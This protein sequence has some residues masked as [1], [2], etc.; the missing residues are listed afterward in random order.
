MF[1]FIGSLESYLLD[2]L[3]K[4]LESETL[5]P[6]NTRLKPSFPSFARS[7][8]FLF[9][10]THLHA[11]STVDISKK[12]TLISILE[13]SEIYLDDKNLSKNEL[14]RGNYLQTYTKSIVNIA[15]SKRTVWIRFKLKNSSSKLIEKALILNSPSLEFISLY[16]EE[17][18]KP[19]LS[20]I[21][22]TKKKHSTIYYS[23]MISIPANSVK[24]YYLKVASSHKSFFFKLT[25]QNYEDFMRDDAFNQAPRL[26]MLGLLLGLMIYAFLLAFYSRDKS[27]FYYASYLFFT[28]WH[29][30]TFL[31]LTQI[32]FPH[33]FVL[34]DMK[35]IIIKLGLALFFAV[36][37]AIS[38][39]KIDKKSWLFKI[40]ILFIL[41]SI[42]IVFIIKT[43]SIVLLIGVAFV[44]FNFIASVLRYLSGYKQ[45]RLFIFGFGVVA[46]A[47][48][49]VVLD[50][51]GLSSVLNHFPNILMWA[52]TIEVLAL[53]LAFADRY[54][55]LEE[56][57][58]ID[59]KNREQIIKNK[60]IQ[61]TAQLNEALKLKSLLL[62]E[63]HHR[64][65]NNLQIIISMIRLQNDKIEDI[66]IKDKFTSLE[67]R[68][69]AIAKTYNML[70]VDENLEN[71]DM[72][73]YIESLLLDIESSMFKLSSNITLETDINASLPLG[74][75]VYIGIIINELVTNSYKYAFENNYGSIFI[76]LNRVQNKYQLTISDTGKGFSYDKNHPSLGLK[77]IHALII[78]Q[79]KGTIIMETKKSS[80]YIIGFE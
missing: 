45:A 29:Q 50:S 37:F 41:L 22:H 67:N 7:L 80:K 47:Y 64:V 69:N 77:L 24:E 48:I 63:V 12:N 71:I 2:F 40:Y 21:S 79:L 76:S 59:D 46:T 43:L 18:I 52:V 19:H 14:L 15:Q 39:L 65:K 11:L 35:L 9:F 66:L 23:Y 78:E 62:K 4:Y 32:Y 1:I 20:G 27:Y 6:N 58:H 75:A 53:T 25:I 8:L 74:K 13:S 3:Q 68:I 10:F 28:L 55:I 31:G 72:E 5:V 42:L 61:K 30:V 57:K 36:L 17:S 34:F 56:I 51:F 44:F 60:V 26:L 49:L 33:W 73:E 70:I 54:K 38:F 16:T